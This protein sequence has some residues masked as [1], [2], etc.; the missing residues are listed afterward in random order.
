MC[1][2]VHIVLRNQCM[3]GSEREKERPKSDQDILIYFCLY[4]RHMWSHVQRAFSCVYIYISSNIYIH[5]LIQIHTC[6]HLFT[7]IHVNSCS[8]MQQY[9]T[10]YYCNFSANSSRVDA[11]W[12]GNG[13]SRMVGDGYWWPRRVGDRWSWPNWGL[14]T[15]SGCRDR[16][17]MITMNISRCWDGHPPCSF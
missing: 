15:D 11:L 3:C 14:Y 8:D 4:T 17:T 9:C 13:R 16:M 10:C 2:F 12:L 5:K 1:V 6:I 7:C